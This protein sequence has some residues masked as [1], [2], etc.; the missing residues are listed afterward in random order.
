MTALTG[1]KLT[2]EERCTIERW[3]V[4]CTEEVT[5]RHRGESWA[6]PCDAIAVAVRFDPTGGEP[7]PVCARHAR[8][9]LATLADLLDLWDHN[10]GTEVQQ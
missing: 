8:G 7:Y 2:T 4:E 10:G 5:R 6:E 9:Q 1:R 3:P